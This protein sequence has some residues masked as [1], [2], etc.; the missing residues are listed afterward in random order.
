[1]KHSVSI[2]IP[3]YNAAQ[4]ITPTV[5]K[6]VAALK[7][8]PD[9]RAEIIIVNDGSSDD[10]SKVAHALQY[11]NISIHIIDQKNK[12][13]FLARKAGVDTA[14]G[15]YVFFVDSRVFIDE[16]A[17]A[18]LS[19]QLKSHP[20][21]KVWNGHVYVAKEGNI[22]ARFGDAITYIGWR[23]YFHKPKLTS[24]GLDDF[25]YYPKGTGCFFI[26]KDLLQYA[27]KEFL[28]SS[29]DLR[30]S[31]DDTL[32]IRLIAGKEKIHLSPDFS[33]TYHARTKLRQ[34]VRH[35][36]GRGM[37]F[38]DGFL[39]PGT[40]FFYPLI[41]FLVLSIAVLVSMVIYPAVIPFLL[42]G[43]VLLWTLELLLAIVLGTPGKD[44]FSLFLLSP[45]FMVVYGAGIWRATI[46][47][48][49]GV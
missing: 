24:Y 16:H 30:Y 10:T 41:G 18:F 34:F 46:K 9:I 33:C 32:L 38:V 8:A 19:E 7:N 3:A 26:P 43:F 2:V 14:K 22:I 12:G 21:R 28:K 35:T 48:L 20:E 23:R 29:H 17:L 49:M 5:D 1:M 27:T 44:A 39:R 31:S 6:I 4:W 37:F 36:F 45:L 15:D 42:I 25:D 40:R 11:K 13:R 47:R